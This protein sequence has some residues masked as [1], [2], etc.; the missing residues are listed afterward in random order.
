MDSSPI[1]YKIEMQMLN[2]VY[3]Q[4]SVAEN[5]ES[6]VGTHCSGALAHWVFLGTLWVWRDSGTSLLGDALAS[7][8]R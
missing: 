6:L 7:I 8:N 2:Q 4:N 3:E 5:E 1:I